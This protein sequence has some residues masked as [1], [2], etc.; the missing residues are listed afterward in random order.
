MI[1]LKM[2]QGSTIQGHTIEGEID[3]V[4]SCIEHPSCKSCKEKVITTA[5][6][7]GESTK[8][9]MLNNAKSYKVLNMVTTLS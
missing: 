6:I 7:L 4:L 3:A 8:C 1:L 2:L 5:E 9:Q